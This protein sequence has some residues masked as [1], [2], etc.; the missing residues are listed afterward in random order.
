MNI[1]RDYDREALDRQYNVRLG[2]SDFQAYFDRFASEGQA[3]R[4]AHPH[5]ADVPYGE[6]ALQTLDFFP[7]RSNGRPLLVFI[8]GGYWRSLDKHQF[9]QVA[10]PYLAQDINVALINYRLAPQVRMGDIAAD[11]GRALR[12]LYA[13]AAALRFDPDAIWLMGHS[14]GAHLAALIASLGAAPVRGLCGISGI[15]DLEPVRLS[16]LNEVL[17]LSPSDALQ[18]SPQLL[19]LPNGVQALLC[20]GGLESAEF[21]RQRDLYAATL[22]QSGHAVE[23]VPLPQ[24]HHLDVVDVAADAHSVL[25]R[26]MVKM[27]LG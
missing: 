8:H 11:C 12:L 24:A 20:A 2:I 1:Y 10:L 22:R 14:A 26:T 4:Q 23:V 3:A 18:A 16:Y 6:D 19:A 9:S 25:T 15:Y 7:G 5:L 21:Q 17:H 13:K 27:M